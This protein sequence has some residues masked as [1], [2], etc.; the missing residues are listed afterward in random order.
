MFL[1]FNFLFMLV[2]YF[3][4]GTMLVSKL[5]SISWDYNSPLLIFNAGLFFLLF[6]KISLS[7][8]IILN[9]ASSV[10]PIYLLHSNLKIQEFLWP[11]LHNLCGT[12]HI[13]R[14]HAFIAM[15][16]MLTCILLDK[17]FAPIYN[18]ITE[19]LYKFLIKYSFCNKL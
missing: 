4:Y 7:S 13:W 18:A 9:V 16:I 3:G 15:L 8:S 1:S 10:F 17:L 11:F 12:S 5:R 14:K 19:Y 2:F 6:E